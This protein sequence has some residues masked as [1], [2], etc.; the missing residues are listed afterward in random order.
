ML[1]LHE[2]GDF[3]LL[4]GFRRVI[5][6]GQRSQKFWCSDLTICVINMK[7]GSYEA[8]LSEHDSIRH[9]SFIKALSYLVFKL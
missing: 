5:E 4:M 3:R 2:L 1:C 8:Y 9:I 7:E 6:L